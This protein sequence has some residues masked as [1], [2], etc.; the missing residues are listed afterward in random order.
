MLSCEV[1]TPLSEE[2]TPTRELEM[3]SCEVETPLSDE[4]TPVTD[5]ETL[6]SEVET[7]LREE[8]IWLSEEL[9]APVAEKIVPISLCWKARLVLT[10]QKSWLTFVFDAPVTKPPAVASG[11]VTNACVQA[12][13]AA[14]WA[15]PRSATAAIASA[16]APSRSA[17][18]TADVFA[19]GGI[20]LDPQIP[21]AVTRALG[22]RTNDRFGPEQHFEP[23]RVIDPN[24]QY[25]QSL[26]GPLCDACVK[27]SRI[28]ADNFSP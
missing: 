12:A 5:V 25:N 4:L 11:L 24:R 17:F 1:E 9:S 16:E 3:L 15:V 18:R 26:Y 10:S 14:R 19:M 21:A 23:A 2:L 27:A 7:P 22:A 28:G 6:F 13:A 8:L 20:Y